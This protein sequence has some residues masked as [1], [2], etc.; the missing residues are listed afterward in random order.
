MNNG[1]MVIE[2]APFDCWTDEPVKDFD[3]LQKSE[4]ETILF[5]Q[6]PGVFGLSEELTGMKMPLPA[7]VFLF[8]YSRWKRDGMHIQDAFPAL[9]PDAR[10]FIMLG[11]TPDQYDLFF[12]EED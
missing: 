2:Y 4:T 1:Y 11:V 7:D 12:P 9:P 6:P 8:C 5:R 3:L 10:D